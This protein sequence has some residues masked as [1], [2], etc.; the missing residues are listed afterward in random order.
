MG[1]YHTQPPEARPLEDD[2]E[3]TVKT[4]NSF[5]P[6]TDRYT[7]DFKK[8][9][10]DKGWVQIDTKQDAS[11]YGTWCNPTTRQIVNYCEGD[12]SLQTYENDQEF[13]AGIR[14]V[15]NWNKES[16]YWIG[17]DMGLFKRKEFT[18]QFMNLGLSDLI[19]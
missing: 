14:T 19:H 3:P 5:N 10:P 9:S 4:V 7:F 11:Y 17:I 2:K 6:I 16:G 8:C 15:A 18:Q 13:A 12:I 1:S